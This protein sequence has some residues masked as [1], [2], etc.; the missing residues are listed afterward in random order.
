MFRTICRVF[1][2]SPTFFL[3]LLTQSFFWH[4]IVM[5]LNSV[6]TWL[7]FSDHLWTNSKFP[8][9]TRGL[10][11]V[12]TLASSALF[13]PPSL[14]PPFATSMSIRAKSK[15]HLKMKIEQRCFSHSMLK[16]QQLLLH[17]GMKLFL[18]ETSY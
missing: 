1:R 17:S 5:V 7:V 2:K 9:R 10:D 4:N 11:L 12:R 6:K 18:K 13:T 3:T 15:F 16:Q 8:I 14:T